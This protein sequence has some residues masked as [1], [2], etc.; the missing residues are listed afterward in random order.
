[1]DK[2]KQA[3]ES[4]T[5]NGFEVYYAAD[6]MAA[7]SLILELLPLTA[8]VM[9]MTSKTLQDVDVVKV[10][11]ESGQYNALHPKV[12]KL[13]LKTQMRENKIMRSVPDWAIGSVHAVTLDGHLVIASAT[14]SQLPAYVYGANHVILVVG[15]QKIVATIED[16][17]K[18]IYEY[19]LPLESDRLMKAYGSKSSVNKILFLQKEAVPKRTKV[20]LVGEALGF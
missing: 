4:L 7:K 9:N 17:F 8:E 14:G 19:V 3:Q 6:R 13:D 12:L 1:M 11:T 2:I 16:A 15:S 5:A 10:I 18:R 20:I